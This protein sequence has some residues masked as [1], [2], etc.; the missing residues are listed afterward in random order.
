[1]YVSFL[2]QLAHACLVD[3]D[4][5]LNG[6]CESSSC[7][8]DSG[9][10][11]D[12]CGTLDLSPATRGTGY[13]LTALGT[14]SWG[15]KIVRDPANS[16]KWHLFAAEFTDH[17]G[18]DYWAPMSRIIRAES[19]QPEGPFVF[20]AEVAGTFAHN[21][22][23]VYSDAAKLFLLYHIGCPFAQPSTCE[24]PKFSCGAG[25]SNNG[26]SGISLLTSPDLLSWTPVVS[27]PGIYL[28]SRGTCT[29]PTPYV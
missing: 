14:S 18:L 20:A 15:G 17:C 11:G 24:A 3:E 22:T 21:P 7:T 25:D 1:M 27:V 13:N 23:V 19:A 4:C 16:S 12:D 10:V 29:S 9:W 8:C 5:S 2:L 28:M 6:V 26:E